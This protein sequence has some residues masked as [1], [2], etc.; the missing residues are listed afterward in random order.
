MIQIFK[1]MAYEET[2]T[3]ILFALMIEGGK[4]LT[5]EDIEYMTGFSRSTIS[6]A[7]SKVT[8]ITQ[9][10][11]IY[12][13]RKPG[14]KKKY[15]YCP[16]TFKEYVTRAF[17]V[18]SDAS[19]L[20]MDFIPGFLDRLNDLSPQTP[21]ITYVKRFLVYMYTATC[22]YER[23][24][25]KS[26]DFLDTMFDDPSYEPNF[27]ELIDKITITI[28][29]GGY[30]PSNDT[31]HQIKQEFIR[32]MTSLSTELLGGN[33][34][35]ISVFLALMLEKDPVT[36]DELINMTGS[37][38]SN[39]SKVLTMM[40][41]LNI[42]EV[43][44]KPKIRKKYYKSNTTIEEYGLGKRKRVQSYYAQIQMMMQKKFLPDLE[45]IE[46]ISEEDK[47]EKDRLIIFFNENFNFFSIFIRYSNAMHTT[48][49][50]VLK[51][52][53]DSYLS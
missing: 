34:E 5:Q 15:Y 24:M 43:I 45:Q 46:L 50:K 4:Y 53:V 28:P 36:Q 35:L 17:L 19:K 47:A 49:Q 37:S 21:S 52:F 29:E 31:S 8:I 38:R 2:I 7:L 39:V 41:E 33:E 48:V 23:I 13:T 12:Y 22:Y 18:T 40:E 26:D 3:G 30:I 14:D 6:E 9:D 32:K 16:I 20:S 11:P 10:F 51:E 27:R 1:L 25:L 42:L 44:R